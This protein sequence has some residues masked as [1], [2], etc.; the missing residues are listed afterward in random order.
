VRSSSVRVDDLLRLAVFGLRVRRTRSLLSGL[1]IALGIA[2][3]VGVLGVT[4]SSQSAL[5]A[6]LDRLGTN[7]LI[8][9]NGRDLSGQETELPR[10]TTTMVGAMAGV[11]H[12]SATARLQPSVY[13]SELVPT[14]QTGGVAV[15][16]T[17]LRLVDTLDGTVATGTF[18]NAATAQYPVVVLGW[19]AA[20]TLG[21]DRGDGDARVWMAGRYWPV[22]GI[23]EPFPLASEID[24][25]VLVGA[26]AAERYLAYDGNATRIYVRADVDRVADVSARLAATVN[27]SAPYQ[28]AVGRP[29]DALAARLAVADASTSL[30]LALGAVALVIAAV[31]IANV[32]LIAV[33]ER[34]GEI[35]LR[36]ALGATKADIAIQFMGEALL[37]SLLGGVGGVTAGAAITAAFAAYRG[38]GTLI[39]G[40][41][42]ALAF[43]AAL[44]IGV[45]AGLYPAARAARLAPTDA[46]RTAG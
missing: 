6:E 25:S 10:T 19:T 41:A 2:L 29:S 12:V 36:R 14:F 13:R 3:I 22:I 15:R 21:I 16:A 32:M 11:D 37:L 26:P 40:A 35:G 20:Q 17:D 18:L 42:F 43:A 38:W 27:P 23:L 45:G 1:G 7:L 33:L 28:V 8:V 39:P 34:R 44:I 31:G 46:L 9:Q 5:L 4:R 30:L 24:L